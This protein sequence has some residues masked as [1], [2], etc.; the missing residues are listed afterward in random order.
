MRSFFTEKFRLINALKGIAFITS[1]NKLPTIQIIHDHILWQKNRASGACC[2]LNLPVQLDQLLW[3]EVCVAR[4][5]MYENTKKK[6]NE[7]KRQLQQQ[8]TTSNWLPKLI[9]AIS[10]FT[11]ACI[12]NRLLVQAICLATDNMSE[13]WQ[14]WKNNRIANCWPMWFAIRLKIRS[15]MLQMAWHSMASLRLNRSE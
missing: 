7:T 8:Q 12:L 15:T 3:I 13:I 6:R 10:Y 2:M 11:S 5:K 4:I 9:A 1:Q 14:K